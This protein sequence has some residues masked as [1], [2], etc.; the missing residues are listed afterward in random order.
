MGAISH[1]CPKAEARRIARNWALIRCGCSLYAL[2]PRQPKAG[3]P[4]GGT[5]K[6]GSGLSA[7]TSYVRMITGLFPRRLYRFFE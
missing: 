7:P 4:S 2:I 5:L 6:K 1:T 3:L